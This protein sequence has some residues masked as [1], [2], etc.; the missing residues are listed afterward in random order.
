MALAKAQELNDEMDIAIAKA[1]VDKRK[2]DNM[3]L[4]GDV[5]N[6]DADGDDDDDDDDDSVDTAELMRALNK[7]SSGLPDMV[8]VPKI[9]VQP[10]ETQRHATPSIHAWTSG[11]QRCR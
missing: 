3:D 11:P 2:D 7:S 5:D 8:A 4:G 10:S 1:T 9:G 6:A